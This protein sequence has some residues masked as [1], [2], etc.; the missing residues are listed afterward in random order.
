M[1]SDKP[2]CVDEKGKL[3]GCCVAGIIAGSFFGAV[4]I[5]LAVV[6]ATLK[7]P[8]VEYDRTE[9]RTPPEFGDDGLSLKSYQ[10]LNIS[11]DN[12]ISVKVQSAQFDIFYQNWVNETIITKIGEVVTELEI[13][14]PEYTNTTIEVPI[15]V[16]VGPNSP[17]YAELFSDYFTRGSFF[18]FLKGNVTAF[19]AKLDLGF[20]IEIENEN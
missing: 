10:Y 16:I 3:T 15:T 4:I 8:S 12:W 14:L 6:V 5:A 18:L 19:D 13:V 1:P 11:N 17:S 20:S 9:V 2:C 7:P